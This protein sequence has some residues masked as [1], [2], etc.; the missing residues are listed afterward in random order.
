MAHRCLSYNNTTRASIPAARGS[1]NAC[2]PA[3]PK[4]PANK[5]GMCS[6][7]VHKM[8]RVLNSVRRGASARYG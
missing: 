3:D 6:A 8:V 2:R 7:S 4:E 1:Y 5:R